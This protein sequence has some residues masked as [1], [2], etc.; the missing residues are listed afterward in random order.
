MKINLLDILEP[1][2]ADGFAPDEIQ[3]V[4]RAFEQDKTIAF[5]G[6]NRLRILKRPV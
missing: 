5:A 2:G 1:L 6:A 4:L 3:A